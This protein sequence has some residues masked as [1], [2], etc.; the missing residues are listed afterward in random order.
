MTHRNQLGI[1]FVWTL[2]VLTSAF[3]KADSGVTWG[4]NIERVEVS[5]GQV[6][7]PPQGYDD[8]DN[9]QVVL[10]GALPNGCYRIADESAVVNPDTKQ[11]SAHVFAYRHTDGA[12]ADQDNLPDTLRPVVPFTLDVSLG[13]LP[14]GMYRVLFQRSASVEGI[15]TFTI[16]R[17]TTSSIDNLPYAAVSSV[18]VPDAVWS[19]QPFHVDIVGSLTSSCSTIDSVSVKLVGDVFVVL[20]VLGFKPNVL[21]A[22]LMVP[23]QRSVDLAPVAEGRYLIHTRSMNGRAVNRVFSAVAH[24]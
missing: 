24:I 19:D 10:D 11:I 15:R 18:W 2:V 5:I 16:D 22:L 9:I 21:C 23:F 3:A 20:P 4:N 1:G 14:A 17:A 6:F 8:N 12:C 13:V 7:I